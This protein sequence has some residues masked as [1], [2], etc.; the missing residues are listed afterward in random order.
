MTVDALP[1]VRPRKRSPWSVRLLAA[2]GFLLA[3]AVGGLFFSQ[4][5]AVEKARNYL[6]GRYKTNLEVPVRD[7]RPDFVFAPASGNP[8]P[9]LGFCWTIEVETGLTRAE[10]MVNPW[11]HEVVDWN[12]DL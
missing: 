9:P 8:A 6:K 7:I 11:T 4:Q 12:V 1:A 10:V 5:I 2:G 3:L